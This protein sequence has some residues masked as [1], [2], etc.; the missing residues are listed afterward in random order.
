MTDTLTP[1]DDAS[2][3]SMPLQG[4]QLPR[5]A[6]AL[7]AGIAVGIAVLA[8]LLAGVGLVAAA[9]IAWILLA[10]GLPAWSRAVE[11]SRKAADRVAGVLV[12]SAFALAMVPLVS[13]VWTVLS[14][15]LPILS[16]QFFQNSMRGILGEGGGIYHALLGT[17][18]ITA[19]ATVISVPIGVLCAIYL[20]EYGKGSKLAR[21]ITFLVDVMTGIPSIVAGLGSSPTRCS[22]SSSAPAS[23][24]ASAARWPSRC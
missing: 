15:G 12:W 11:G 21:V 6:P 22:C 13:L 24:W 14:K 16:A 9:L 23:G 2:P 17:L 19:L 10:V 4:A 5:Y 7:A 3:H 18:I 8:V 1:V 20:V